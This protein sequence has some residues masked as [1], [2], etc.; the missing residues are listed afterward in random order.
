MTES[1]P[2]KSS[3]KIMKNLK[4]I[5]NDQDYGE[6]LQEIERIFDAIPGTTEGDR[7][8]ILVTL[9]EA[10]EAQQYPVQLPDPIEAIHYH[11]DRL[12]LSRKDL[13]PMIGTR[14]RVSEI[15]NRKRPLTLTMIRKLNRGLGISTEVLIQEYLTR[16]A[17][18]KLRKGADPSKSPLDVEGIDLG[19]SG[20]EVL[21][22]V[23]EEREVY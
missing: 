19:K 6:A 23:R 5:H 15:L 10:Y 8:E 17:G 3:R 18:H 21:T 9:V 11:M 13:Q 4:P 22:F 1:M 20:Q 14:A 2:L 16:E 7:L 12:G